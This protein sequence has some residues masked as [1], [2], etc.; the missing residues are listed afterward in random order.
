M[1]KKA[2]AATSNRLIAKRTLLRL[3]EFIRKSGGQK[4]AMR[5]MVVTMPRVRLISILR[6]VRKARD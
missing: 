1:S 6:T 3:R 5:G 4:T 2:T